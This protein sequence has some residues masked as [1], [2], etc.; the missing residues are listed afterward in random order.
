MVPGKRSGPPSAIPHHQPLAVASTQEFLLED[1]RE[2]EYNPN[3]MTDAE[4][5]GL[6][7]SMVEFG[8]VEYPVIN[9]HPGRHGVIVG[10]THRVRTAV[11]K[12]QESLPCIV[13]D[14][15]FEREKQLNLRL[16]KHRGTPQA[17]LMREFFEVSEL[18]LVGY[19]AED[20]ADWDMLGEA[21]AADL[22]IAAAASFAPTA[23]PVSPLVKPPIVQ[24]GGPA[25]DAADRFGALA[26]D[27]GAMAGASPP[28]PG[29]VGSQPVEPVG[30]DLGDQGE[31]PSPP[32]VVVTPAPTVQPQLTLVITGPADKISACRVALD[33]L[34][35]QLRTDLAGALFHAL[36][37]SQEES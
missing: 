30:G 31:G 8:V 34:R 37:T 15:T 11:A 16:N 9:V 25:N 17:E 29:P 23:S 33:R 36:I 24:P 22:E 32:A 28:A 1:L 35:T 10:G 2:P 3:R 18:T 19:T 14:L 21:G 27:A 13:V 26:A 6:E 20:L 12:G 7:A 4:L 5:S